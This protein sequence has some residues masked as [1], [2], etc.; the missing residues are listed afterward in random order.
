MGASD[1]S[2]QVEA[3][4][5]SSRDI[6]CLVVVTILIGN[7]IYMSQ[8]V[9]IRQPLEVSGAVTTSCDTL[10]SVSVYGMGE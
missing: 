10:G 4:N 9:H 8:C 6:K 3:W 1:D 5:A 2:Y 7:A